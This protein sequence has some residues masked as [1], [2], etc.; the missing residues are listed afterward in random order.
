MVKPCDPGENLPAPDPSDEVMAIA[1]ADLPPGPPIG[2]PREWVE[3]DEAT[4]A[5]L[6]TE[7][8]ANRGVSRE[9]GDKVER[10]EER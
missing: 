2:I 7:D 5:G 1:G 10:D 6:P 4:D 9:V 3:C 8:G